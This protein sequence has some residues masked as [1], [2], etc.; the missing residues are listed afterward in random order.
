MDEYAYPILQAAKKHLWPKSFNPRCFRI[1][2]LW[3]RNGLFWSPHFLCK[4]AGLVSISVGLLQNTFYWLRQCSFYVTW[5]SMGEL[6]NSSVL[7][8]E[9]PFS[10][11]LQRKHS[12]SLWEMA[13]EFCTCFADKQSYR[14]LP[15]F[16]TLQ[17]CSDGALKRLSWFNLFWVA[18]FPRP[19]RR[20][21]RGN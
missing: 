15:L 8:L 21:W 6:S 13:K 12:S 3:T 19:T 7:G 16:L 11:M 17:M 5:R 4:L 2:Q 18:L 1:L 20:P 14:I 10:V 9:N